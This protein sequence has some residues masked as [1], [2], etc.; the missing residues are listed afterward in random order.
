MSVLKLSRLQVWTTLPVNES[1]V[2][3]DE[4]NSAN[5]EPR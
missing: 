3:N 5:S 4:M 1:T 2:Q